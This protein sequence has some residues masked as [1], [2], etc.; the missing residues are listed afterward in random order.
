MT[1]E[2]P[3]LSGFVSLIG[4]PNVGK[5]SIMNRLVGEKVAIIS[6]KPQTTRNKIEGIIT[7]DRYQVIFIDTPGMHKPRN[8]LG[9]YMMKVSREALEE[10]DLVLYIVDA[11]SGLGRGEKFV[12][13]QLKKVRTSILL[14]INKIDLVDQD[15]LNDIQN[16]YT[17]MMDFDGVIWVSALTGQNMDKLMDDILKFLP[18]GPKYFP[19]DM[20]TGQ[21]TRV[22]VSELIREKALELLREEIPHGIGVEI[23]SMEHRDENDV[24]CI[25]A[26]I[27][28]EKS[29]HKGIIIGKGGKMLK[30][31][32]TKA[33]QD[34]ERL[35]GNRTFIELWVK[36]KDDWRNNPQTIKTL[37][38]E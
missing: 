9:E 10:V 29:S 34:I 6:S 30:D 23:D 18:Q 7:T 15:K 36:V 16:Q 11:S 20:I 32:G 38:Y 2:T 8:K 3:F 13:E 5:S 26:T 35:L 31:I 1:M 19:D 17:D 28:C 37:G 25:R 4:R 22:L 33:R 24:M 12:I 14:V 21:P 27:Y